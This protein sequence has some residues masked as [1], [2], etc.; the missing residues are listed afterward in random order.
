MSRNKF[1]SINSFFSTSLHRH[2]ALAFLNS[3][4]VSNDLNRVLFVIEGDPR[5]VKTKPFADI[6]SISY[7]SDESEVLYMISSIFRLIDIRRNDDD[8]QL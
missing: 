4:L 8:D 7:F 3:S 1:I 6:S 5:V 2:K